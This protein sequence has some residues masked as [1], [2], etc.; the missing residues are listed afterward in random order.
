MGRNVP[1][2]AD[3]QHDDWNELE[4]K[5]AHSSFCDRDSPRKQQR[6]VHTVENTP[7]C[8]MSGKQ[9]P[10]CATSF[11]ATMLSIVMMCVMVCACVRWC[12][13]VRVCDGVCVNVAEEPMHAHTRLTACQI[14]N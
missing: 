1:P 10:D 8:T 6:I 2:S 13:M 14:A 7:S 4:L 9:S 5:T 3:S 12:V 11:T